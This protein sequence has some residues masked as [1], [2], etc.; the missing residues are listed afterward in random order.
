[1]P[2]QGFEGVV[3]KINELTY[4]DHLD[5]GANDRSHRSSNAQ[6]LSQIGTEFLY[7]RIHAMLLLVRVGKHI[8]GFGP[9]TLAQIL[10][11]RVVRFDFVR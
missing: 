11:R 1:M 3:R 10:F 5:E 2:P 9:A 6:M 7:A 8:F 4:T